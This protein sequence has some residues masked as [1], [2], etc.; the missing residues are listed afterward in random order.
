[1]SNE[2]GIDEFK[3]PFEDDEP[4]VVVVVDVELDSFAVEVDISS[5]ACCFK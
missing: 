4:L 1:M 2:E 5:F 3:V